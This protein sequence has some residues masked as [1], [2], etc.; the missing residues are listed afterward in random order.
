MRAIV[1]TKYGAPEVLQLKEVEKP[2]PGDNEILVKIFATPVTTGDARL[3]RADPFL[4]RLFF[5]LF[6]PKIPI[7]GGSLAGEIEAIGKNVT[8]F[9]K[10]DQI[11]A[12]TGRKMSAHAEYTTLA[13]DGLIAFKPQ[14]CNYE[15][16]ASI[17]FGDGT[18]LYFLKKANIQAGQKI[19][20]IGG[21]GSLGVAAIQLAKYFGAEVH[22]VCSTGNIDLV[23]SLG[24]DR[25]FDYTKEDFSESGESY[26]IIY[27]TVGKMS[28]KKALKVLKKNGQLI[29]AAGMMT[30]MMEAA[31][32]SL[33]KKVKI[34]AGEMKES[35][36]DLE[37]LAS[38]YE[39][40]K[41]H[42]VIDR[43]FPL[44]EI[45]AAH[46]LV[47]SGHKKGNVIISIQQ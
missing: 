22:T 1:Y 16:V 19:L 3:R 28:V 31:W 7:L 34:I 10:G 27:D 43:V 42:A 20:I 38:L 35:K 15:E 32:T 26:D 17:P 18:S 6:R 21:S 41:M 8:R 4:V 23:K 2:I 30:Q 9:K 25:V 29:V 33:T 37:F 24:A 39:S 11:F 46:R 13:E 47:D 45:R 40:G 12:S 44:E 5:G 36:A 14:N